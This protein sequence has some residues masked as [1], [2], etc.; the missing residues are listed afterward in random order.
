VQRVYLTLCF[1][2]LAACGAPSASPDVGETERDAGVRDAAQP[3][4]LGILDDAAPSSPD[5]GEAT[6]AAQASAR[7]RL[8]ASYLAFLRETPDDT[9]SNGLRGA[10]LADVCALW[11]ALD[12][13][14]QAT[15][16]TLTARLEGSRLADGSSALDH[17]VR[18]YRLAGG[19]G[20]T[21]TDP[22]SCGGG[23]H[24]RV[25]VSIDGALH[26]SLVAAHD[27]AGAAPFDLADVQAGTSWRD[28][29]D[30]AGPHAP[31][32]LGVETNE[33]APRGQAQLFR[34]PTSALAMQPLGR[35]DLETLVDPYALELDQ[36]YDCVHS[37]NP[38]CT[39]VFY[40]PLCAP[41][42]SQR[43][44]D[45]YGDTYGAVDLAWRPSGCR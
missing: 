3:D 6:D 34:D 36:D 5:A 16:A 44:V 23:E 42:A 13:S 4:A 27:R 2:L 10:D 12:P 29:H 11:D 39:Y 40:G 21:T 30:L 18:L 26:A 1:A 17:V 32:D 14:S 15:F 35:L 37:S 28:T 9:Q 20:A 33:G 38:L 43:G 45:V 8:I 31:F 22:G 24:N 41:A 25:L 7:D 19:E